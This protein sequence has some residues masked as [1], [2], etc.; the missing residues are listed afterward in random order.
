MERA[1]FTVYILLLGFNGVPSMMCG[2]KYIFKI[3]IIKYGHNIF[4]TKH[5]WQVVNDR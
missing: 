2:D 3:V 1:Y 4:K 5:T